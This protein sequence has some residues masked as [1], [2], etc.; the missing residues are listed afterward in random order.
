MGSAGGFSSCAAGFRAKRIADAEASNIAAT[1]IFKRMARVIVSSIKFRLVLPCANH[2]I[3][4]PGRR[5]GTPIVRSHRHGQ[6]DVP[7]L[8]VAM[9]P[10]EPPSQARRGKTRRYASGK[11]KSQNLLNV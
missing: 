8:D 7:R 2:C 4:G 1:K 6:C 10:C 3:K 5:Y 9:D 11:N